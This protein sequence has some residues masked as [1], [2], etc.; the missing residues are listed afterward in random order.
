MVPSYWWTVSRVVC[1]FWNELIVF[2][3]L[4]L[5]C[6]YETTQLHQYI[7]DMAS[8]QHTISS[9]FNKTEF[10]WGPFFSFFFFFFAVW[11]RMLLKTWYHTLIS[12]CQ[13][14]FKNEKPVCA[15]M[16]IYL[17]WRLWKKTWKT[18][19]NVSNQQNPWKKFIFHHQLLC[20]LYKDYIFHK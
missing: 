17:H 6:T 4:C 18:K 1:D 5:Y 7:D 10:M 8:E 2:H 20:C 19:H 3:S 11:S 12:L 15:I 9:E 13:N 14:N 16:K